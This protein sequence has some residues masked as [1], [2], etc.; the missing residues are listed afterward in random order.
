MIWIA[1]LNGAL[2]LAAIGAI[3]V[4]GITP[5]IPFETPVSALS[6]IFDSLAPW[7]LATAFALS[8]LAAVSGTPKLG[9]SLGILSIGLS[10]NL[11]REHHANSLRLTDGPADARIVFLNAETD[12]AAQAYNI[13]QAAISVNPD[14]VVFTEAEAI[15]PAL[16]YL[17]DEFEFVSTCTFEQCEMVIATRNT[18]SR[19]WKLK[20]KETWDERYAVTELDLGQNGSFYLASVHLAKPWLVGIAESELAR[21]RAQFDFLDGPVLAVGDFN[22]APWGYSLRSLLKHTG[23]KA[24]RR[25]FPSWPASAGPIGVP[26]DHALVHNGMRITQIQPFAEGLGSNHR[27]FIVDIVLP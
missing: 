16:N 25:P 11:F 20:L 13:V 10:A 7:I 14:A 12:N 19:F 2:L 26:I 8:A 22:A 21:L 9:L 23:Y 18:P 4:A 27:G 1:R 3:F 6:R 17:V 15:Q 24:L 5:Y